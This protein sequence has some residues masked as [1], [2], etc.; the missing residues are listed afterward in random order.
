MQKGKVVILTP[1]YAG[2]LMEPYKES[3]RASAPLLNEAGWQDGMGCEFMNPYISFARATMTRRALDAGA[4]V[5]VYIDWDMSWE[6]MDLVTLIETPGDV[7]CGTYRF[8]KDEEEYMGVIK[9]DENDRPICRADG[10]INALWGPAGFLKVTTKAIDK[11]MEGYPDLCFGPRYA[12]SVDLFSHGAHGRAWW[13][14]DAAF[15]RNWRAIGGEVWIIPNL[16]LTHW[17]GETPYPGNYHEFL[18]RQPGGS[19]DPALEGVECR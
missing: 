6:P 2:H 18:L 14:E 11:F 15:G 8:K 9:T 5:V 1:S 4:D 17:S 10:C 13:G 12:Q 7:V 16:S 19:K 3:L